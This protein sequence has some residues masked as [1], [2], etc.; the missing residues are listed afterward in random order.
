MKGAAELAIQTGDL[1][2]IVEKDD[3]ANWWKARKKVA[4]EEEDE[5]EGLVPK[6]H[7]EQVHTP[8]LSAINCAVTAQQRCRHLVI[9]NYADCIHRLNRLAEHA[10]YTIIHDKQKKSFPSPMVR[11]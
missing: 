5:P 10:P 7:I 3:S 9:V 6:N 11:Y 2:Y 1:L 8:L 4:N